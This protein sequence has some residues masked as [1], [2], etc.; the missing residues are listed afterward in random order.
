VERGQKRLY[1]RNQGCSIKTNFLFPKGEKN[2]KTCTCTIKTNLKCRHNGDGEV[3]S[4]LD[5]A[6]ISADQHLLQWSGMHSCGCAA[7]T[8]FLRSESGAGL[9][10]SHCWLLVQLAN[11]KHF[12]LHSLIV[13]M[14]HL[15]CHNLNRKSRGMKQFIMIKVFLLWT[16][17]NIPMRGSLWR[18]FIRRRRSQTNMF[19]LQTKQA[20]T[21]VFVS[22]Y[23][24]VF[25]GIW[26]P[27]M[28]LFSLFFS[29]VTAVMYVGSVFSNCIFAGKHIFPEMKY[30][31]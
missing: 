12:D 21:R 29:R 22:N 31:C 8:P 17:A 2:L 9:E 13:E 24:F 20:L 11:Q 16:G 28:E 15:S 3:L 4:D 7:L 5:G 14:S 26:T 23:Y 19:L 25:I 30:L 10:P 27:R 18:D 1:H 6:H